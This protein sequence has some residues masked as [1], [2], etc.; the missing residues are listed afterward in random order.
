MGSIFNRNLTVLTT[1]QY[2]GLQ[3]LSLKNGM[4]EEYLDKI[5]SVMDSAVL[6]YSKVYAVRVDLRFPDTFELIDTAVITRFFESLKA[7]LKAD[8]L[9][10]LRDTSIGQVHESEL[11]DIWVKEICGR[12]KCH[13]HVCLF[14]NGHAYNRL[15]KF[16]LGRAN[17]YNRIH[18]AWASA[19][20]LDISHAQGLI[21]FP[22][23]AQYLLCRNQPNFDSIYQDLFKRLS[24]FA[25]TDTKIYGNGNHNFGCSRISGRLQSW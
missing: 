3:I 6:K 21:H 18:K 13:Y 8:Y 15:G 19:L 1:P 20:R 11:F 12:D 5:R 22:E 2:N 23:N 4:I 16:E 14:F 9:A 7:Q 25:K 17:M 10:K 24:Y